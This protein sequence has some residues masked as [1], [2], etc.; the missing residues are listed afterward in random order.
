MIKD[1]FI[2]EY[3]SSLK[4]QLYKLK[5]DIATTNFTDMYSVGKLQGR[6][7]GIELS[8]STLE[9]TYQQQDI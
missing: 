2:G 9:D 5:D 6:V 4:S 8:L 7:E 3:I 1:K